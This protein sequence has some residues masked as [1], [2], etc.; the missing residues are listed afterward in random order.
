V[1]DGVSG[2]VVVGDSGGGGGGGRE[3]VGVGELNEGGVGETAGE[4]SNDG[5]N[6]GD[7]VREGVGV[8]ETAV[9]VKVAYK[10]D[11]AS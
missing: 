10:E 6:C 3:E 7:D 5:I 8:E 1:G 9:W 2:G 4:F 11:V